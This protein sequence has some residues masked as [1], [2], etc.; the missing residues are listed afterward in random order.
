LTAAATPEI[1]VSD[2]SPSQRLAALGITLPDA[3]KPVASYI[4]VR[5]S[6]NQAFV[7]GQLPFEAGKLPAEGTVPSSVSPDQAKAMAR[8][9]VVNA[10]ACLQQA[11]GSIDRVRGVVKV[12]VFVASDAG[13]GGQPGIANG[14]SDLLVE[15][16]GEA[17]RHAR[18]A[19]GVPALPLNAPVEVEFVFEI[20]GA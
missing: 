4:P 2:P 1:R 12:G 3:P 19:V 18:A 14:A 13:F 9:C 15:V 6:G 11:L 16:F 8:R 10:L 5:V 7:S 17:G 20:V